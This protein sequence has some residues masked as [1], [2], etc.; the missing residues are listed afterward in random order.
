MLPALT[1]SLVCWSSRFSVSF[2]AR[3]SV[4]SN[5]TRDSSPCRPLQILNGAVYRGCRE[6]GKESKICDFTK[7]R[8][9]KEGD[10]GQVQRQTH[11]RQLQSRAAEGPCLHHLQQSTT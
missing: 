2:G 10:E 8:E 3:Q 5:E 7:A 1:V 9:W 6:V 4:N 11:L